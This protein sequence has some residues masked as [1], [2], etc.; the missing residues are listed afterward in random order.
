MTVLEPSNTRKGRE[1][2]GIQC[3]IRTAARGGG[4][5]EGREEEILV[6]LW[7]LGAIRK[8]EPILYTT[9]WL[10]TGRRLDAKCNLLLSEKWQPKEMR[11]DY[12]DYIL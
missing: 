11:Q 4:A 9:S 6:G 7:V 3:S 8:V 1:I 12:A 10:T 2:P 5:R